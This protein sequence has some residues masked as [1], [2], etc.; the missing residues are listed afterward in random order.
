MKKIVFTLIASRDAE[1][2]I[3]VAK[4]LNSKKYEVIFFTFYG[5]AEK[6]ISEA[7]YQ[8]FNLH[9]NI[10]NTKVKSRKFNTSAIEV[11][12]R[13][14][15]LCDL[16]LHER[17]TF[18]CHNES[19][20][21]SKCG[22]YLDALSS[23]LNTIRPDVVVQELGGFIAPMSFYYA[24]R[25]N[26]IK[27]IFLEPMM[28][29]GTIGFVEDAI[30]YNIRVK[31]KLTNKNVK[32]YIDKYITSQNA[33]IPKKDEHHFRDATFVKFFN[34]ANLRK[35]SLKVWYKYLLGLD[36]E[37]GAI[38][39][40]VWRNFKMLINRKKLSSFYW[41]INNL[42][43]DKRY[44][45]FPLHVPLDFQLTVRSKEWLNQ[46]SLLE[47]ISNF[48]PSGVELWIKEHPAAIGAYSIKELDKLLNS[49]NV[50]I[51]HPLENS[52]SIIH[53]ASAVITINSK[54]GAEALMQGKPLFVLGQAFYRNHG[55]SY[56]ISSISELE[57]ELT[58]FLKNKSNL[59][60]SNKKIQDFLSAVWAK[61]LPGELYV[62]TSENINKFAS[63]LIKALE[64]G[65]SLKK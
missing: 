56:D 2:F 60:P 36:Q 52:F 53:N 20:L 43:D 14:K 6:E 24:C 49:P 51:I 29:Q 25:K 46:I 62:N 5:P 58:D 17:L 65:Q 30:N 16:I 12:Y 34:F 23:W 41:P 1:F 26:N 9:S 57:K 22:A 27:H 15:S 45:Y 10:F 42:P 33:V 63:S 7:G 40:H 8:F 3:N 39:N 28:F 4:Q 48:L 55:I 44:V 61:S 50:K 35:L 19:Y 47:R 64:L 32:K 59:H 31:S 54:V 18:N 21:F 37:Y 11:K 13:I 38:A